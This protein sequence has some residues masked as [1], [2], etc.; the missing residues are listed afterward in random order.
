MGAMGCFLSYLATT[1]TPRRS[2]IL[3]PQLS[4]GIINYKAREDRTK[5]NREGEVVRLTPQQFTSTSPYRSCR[6]DD[7]L[8]TCTNLRNNWFLK[9]YR[10]LYQIPHKKATNSQSDVLTRCS[11]EEIPEID[12]SSSISERQQLQRSISIEQT[13]LT[14]NQRFRNQLF[15]RRKIPG[16]IPRNGNA[17][18]MPTRY[19]PRISTP[20][21]VPRCS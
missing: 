8:L 17:P 10:R 14:P 20:H 19:M 5:T 4:Y 3:I 13:L 9:F 12:C 15:G 16:A 1:M 11:I 6:C 7:R 2:P 18:V 21:T